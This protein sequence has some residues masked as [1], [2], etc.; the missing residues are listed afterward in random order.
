M[1]DIVLYTQAT[2]Q[3]VEEI[4]EE[5]NV[6]SPDDESADKAI[7]KNKKKIKGVTVDGEDTQES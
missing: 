7:A 5:L 3:L 1:V 2:E 4:K 6:E